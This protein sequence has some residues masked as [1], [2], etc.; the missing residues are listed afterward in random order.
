MSGDLRSHHLT[1]ADASVLI[2]PL[3]GLVPYVELTAAEVTTA[4]RRVDATA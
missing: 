1:V 2:Y 3:E 4:P